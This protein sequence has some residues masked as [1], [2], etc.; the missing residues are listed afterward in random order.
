MLFYVAELLLDMMIINEKQTKT[1]TAD[2]AK[3]MKDRQTQ[4]MD[5][6][7]VAK[8]AFLNNLSTT[9]FF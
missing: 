8:L 6:R 4:P 3:I 5:K 9:E 1:G 7:V 2:V